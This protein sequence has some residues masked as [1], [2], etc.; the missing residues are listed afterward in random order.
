[1]KCCPPHTPMSLIAR[2]LR[3]RRAVTCLIGS[4][5]RPNGSCNERC[6]STALI[7]SAS[8]VL[9]AFPFVCFRAVSF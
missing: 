8:A 5:Q 4:R 1:M 2:A 7:H 6:D 3:F 9:F